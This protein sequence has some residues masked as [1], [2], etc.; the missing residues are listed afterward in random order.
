QPPLAEVEDPG[1][2]GA[3]IRRAAGNMAASTFAA[4]ANSTCRACPVRTACPVSGKGRQLGAAADPGRREAEA[5]GGPAE[6]GGP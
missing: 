2:A 3:V 5:A 4:V 1:W 6:G